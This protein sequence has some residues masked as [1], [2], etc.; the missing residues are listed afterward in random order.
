M[1]QYKG[2]NLDKVMPQLHT[3]N[4][5]ELTNDQAKLWWET[6]SSGIGADEEMGT[7]FEKGRNLYIHTDD[8]RFIRAVNEGESLDDPAVQRRL[9]EGSL[10]GRLF[11][12]KS[13]DD[14][15]WPRQVVTDPEDFSMGVAIGDSPYSMPTPEWP[16][17]PNPLPFWKYLLWPYSSSVR[18]EVRS[19]QNQKTFYDTTREKILWLDKFKDSEE[20]SDI[21]SDDQ[22]EDM[23]PI[24]EAREAAR[25]QKEMKA[26]REAFLNEHNQKKQEWNKDVS[27]M[28]LDEYEKYRDQIY[29]DSDRYNN[30]VRD[31]IKNKHATYEEV[32][33]GVVR[34]LEY[35]LI[36]ATSSSD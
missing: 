11:T 23:R 9:L 28:S 2:S 29:K 10:N 31:I 32:L 4:Y 19:Y 1:S 6:F 12:R 26:E 30:I 5:P 18:E 14:Y 27:T 8:H 34:V 16:D 35:G 20:H 13:S 15:T 33:D 25:Q 24:R 21:I 7:K 3:K 36:R 22:I 17:R